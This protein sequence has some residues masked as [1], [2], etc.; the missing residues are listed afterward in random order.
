M[1]TGSQYAVRTQSV[2]NQY[3]VNRQSVRRQDVNE[4]FA[5]INVIFKN[6]QK[7]SNSRNSMRKSEI[8]RVVGGL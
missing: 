2:S 3:A 4:I 5:L 6:C 7:H 8:P 1:S